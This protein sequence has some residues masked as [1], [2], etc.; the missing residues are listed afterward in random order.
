MSDNKFRIGLV[1]IL[2]GTFLS[3]LVEVQSYICNAIYIIAPNITPTASEK[4]VFHRV[5]YKIGKNILVQAVNQL[6]AQIMISYK[7][8]KLNKKV[9]FWI[10]QGGDVLLLPMLTIK[11][12]RSKVMLLMAGN[13]EKEIKYKKSLLNGFQVLFR[14]INC[15][16]TDGIIL[17]SKSLMQQ[18]QLGN[19]KNKILV[20]DH[21]FV[22][23]K[24]N[25]IEKRFGDR[26]AV[27]GYIGRLSPEKGISN[28]IR[29]IPFVL[30]KDID[31]KFIIVGDGP[32]EAEVAEYLR[33]KQLNDK[34][35]LIGRVP[36]SEVPRYL[37]ELRLC[38]LP[39]YTEGMPNIVLES[40]ACG[41]PIL[42]TPVGAITDVIL[43]NKNGFI[44]DNNTPQS[45][46]EGIISAL[47][48]SDLDKISELARAR[49]EKEFSLEKV[50]RKYLN[51]TK[52]RFKSLKA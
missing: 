51:A 38:L 21:H 29:A 27:V 13:L 6:T 31:I 15:L 12:L 26:D 35:R 42:S 32:L 49:V 41:T 40:M 48:C 50:R 19:Y 24:T 45:I 43:N 39:S 4:V 7:I 20:A 47:S 52:E 44:I 9:D 34:V 36:H 11:V 3:N 16:L 28:L 8:A 37:N 10:F 2:A 18:W 22:N 25:K 30:E 1:S 17:Y 5:R 23:L 46:A 14:K 33:E